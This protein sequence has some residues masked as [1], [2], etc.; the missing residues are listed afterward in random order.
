M[1]MDVYLKIQ[2]VDGEA[3]QKGYENWIQ[4]DTWNWGSSTMGAAD[5]GGGLVGGKVSM[6]D[7]HFTKVTDKSSPKLFQSCCEGK[8]FD[9]ILLKM[10]RMPGNQVVMDFT[11][12]NCI[13]TSFQTGG[14]AG[15]S[16]TPSESGA[17][18]FSKVDFKFSA[19]K[20]DGTLE[21]MVQAGWDMAKATKV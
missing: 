16:G 13:I 19:L 20:E 2:G 1:A 18:N 11:L 5:R 10:V 21:G 8:V 14:G 7:F 6:Q 17:L 4:L 12:F 9:R 15:D 3:T